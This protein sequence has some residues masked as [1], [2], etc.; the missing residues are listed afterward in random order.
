MEDSQ[1][2]AVISGKVIGILR[3]ADDIAEMGEE[4][5]DLQHSIRR[6]AE[7]S[8]SMGMCIN[9]EK[10]EVQLIGKGIETL[11]IEIDGQRLKHI[12][13]FVSGRNHKRR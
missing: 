11:N 12:N 6:I 4:E 13:N 1:T 10:T 8:N 3:F 7:K 9:I 5:V 2:E